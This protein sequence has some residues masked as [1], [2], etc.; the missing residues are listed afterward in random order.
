MKQRFL[1]TNSDRT[2]GV[3]ATGLGKMG[4]QYQNAVQVQSSGLLASNTLK[5]NRQVQQK[6]VRHI[7]RIAPPRSNEQSPCRYISSQRAPQP[8]ARKNGAKAISGLQKLYQ[9]S[10]DLNPY[11]P[12]GNSPLST[13]GQT[14]SSGMPTAGK[15]RGSYG[16]KRHS[17]QHYH[18]PSN[19]EYSQIENGDEESYN[20]VNRSSSVALESNAVRLSLDQLQP[21]QL[22]QSHMQNPS[23]TEMTPS[24]TEHSVYRSSQDD[25]VILTARVVSKSQPRTTKSS[26]KVSQMQAGN[27][28][29]RILLKESEKLSKFDSKSSASFATYRNDET[30]K[31]PQQTQTQL[32]D[33]KV[34]EQKAGPVKRQKKNKRQSELQVQQALIEKKSNPSKKTTR[35]IKSPWNQSIDI[36][37]KKHRDNSRLKIRDQFSKHSSLV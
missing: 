23:E 3:N 25:E 20:I 7:K 2:P 1:P 18:V 17:V 12:S 19:A 16:A 24:M 27:V 36:M 6:S 26:A 35:E 22:E 28:R 9:S 29:H 8:Q 30:L 31:V 33:L 4:N 11:A 37:Q 14:G 32:T 21:Y 5:G 10:S 15:E 13:A 34:Y